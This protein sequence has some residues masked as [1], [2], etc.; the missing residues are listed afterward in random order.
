MALLGRA[1]GSICALMTIRATAR[2]RGIEPDFAQLIR[3]AVILPTLAAFVLLTGK[4][5]AFLVGFSRSSLARVA[6]L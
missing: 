6:W 4:R 3:M 2:L 5:E 1:I